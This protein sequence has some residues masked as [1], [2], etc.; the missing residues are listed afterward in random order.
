ME[1]YVQKV[2]QQPVI[3]VGYGLAKGEVAFSVG[4]TAAKQALS[5]IRV[6]KIVAVLVFAAAVY[7]SEEV[8]QGVHEVVGETPVFGATTAGEIFGVINRG[9]VCVTIL[10]SPYLRVYCGVGVKVSED[11]RRA[12]DE[13]LDTPMVR[14]FFYD[15]E[16]REQIRRQ[17]RDCFVML[18]PPGITNTGAYHGFKIL[19]KLKEKA[20]GAFTVVGGG[21][22]DDFLEQNRVFWGQHAYPDS[23]LVAI[24]ETELQFGISLTHGFRSTDSRAVVTSVDDEEVLTIDGESA[25]DAYSRLV[26]V[27]KTEM[28]G[29]HPAHVDGATFGISDTLGQHTVNLV[30]SI[31]T[32]GGIIL[33]R[34]VSVGTVLTR[35]EPARDSLVQ[36]GAEGIRS[37]IIRGGI[38]DLALCLV[39]YCSF[40][41]RLLGEFT[42]QEFAGMREVLSGQP[43]VGFCCCGEIGVAADSVSRFNTSSVACL[44]LG[45]QLSRIA[46]ITIESNGLLAKLERQSNVLVRI[47]EDLLKEIAERKKIEAALRESETKLKDFAHAVP[48]I[49]M[50][51]DEDGRYVEVFESGYQHL[52][53]PKEELKGFVLHQRFSAK[54]ADQI[55]RQIRE[56]IASGAPR[57]RIYEI[58]IDGEQRFFEGRTAPMSFTVNEKRMVAAVAL[59]VTERRKTERMLEFAYELRRKSD[60]LNNIINGKTKV[61]GRM[62]A[63]V[64]TFGI[65]LSLPLFC[66]LLTVDKLVQ[67]ATEGEVTT[68]LQMLD[69]IIELLSRDS[70]YLVWDCRDRIGVICQTKDLDYDWKCSRQFALQLQE[71]IINYEPGLAIR[72]GVSNSQ[73]GPDS[74]SE[75]YRQAWNA[76]VTARC[77]NDAAQRISHFSEIGIG[78]ILVE[79][80]GKKSAAFFVKEK[81]GKILEYDRKKGTN[82]LDTL[83]EVLQSNSLREAAQKMF[84]H[85]KT[86]AFRKQRIETILGVSIDDFETKLALAAAVKLYRLSGSKDYPYWI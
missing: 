48:D 82:L 50:I 21:A 7:N 24:F 76:L 23:V 32:R 10:A 15:P 43:L 63:T 86:M 74:I 72:I 45:R 56:T 84:I 61:D 5:S 57:C 37:A 47:N 62:L 17:G 46:Q 67:G 68:D 64:K 12:L 29:I 18:V 39:C 38:T 25:V 8:L 53:R 34:P 31:T 42:E 13:A 65:D 66:C 83:E 33:S 71:K 4:V 36:A 20:D 11:W 70:D 2:E 6:H 41:P 28:G 85:Y 9:S 19:E 35:M 55:L 78:Q 52:K 79:L 51:I 1:G 81:L 59:N 73:S 40:R 22:S 75:A 49:S 26:G 54:Y 69:R 44:V 16:Y 14:P 80:G 3:E 60:F 58:E 30:D 77:Q 27:P